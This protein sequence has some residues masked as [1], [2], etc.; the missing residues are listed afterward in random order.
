MLLRSSSTPVLGSLI[1]SVTESPNNNHHHSELHT[2]SS[3]IHQNCSK[4][5]CNNGGSQKFNKSLMNSPSIDR[6]PKTGF[7]RVQSEGNLEELDSDEFKFSNQYSK[8]FARKPNLCSLE[9]IPS[10]THHILGVSLEVDDSD[11]EDDSEEEI[12]ETE[13]EENGGNSFSVD[14]FVSEEVRKSVNGYGDLGFENEGKMYLA[15]GLGISG[16]GF[17]DVCGNGG[18]HGGGGS[19]RPVAFNRDG[20]GDNRGVSMEEHYKS[21]MQGNPGNPLFLRNYAQFLY[22]TKGDLVGAEEY[23]SRAI[24]A[25]P[26]D[27]EILAQYAKLIWELHRD[28][29]RAAN[30]FERAV[31]ASSQDSHIHAAYASFLWDIEDDEDEEEN[32]AEN[33][34]A[35]MPQFYHGIMA[36]ASA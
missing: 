6:I 33:S 2:Q 29:Q 25:D 21:M 28:K 18:G 3:T 8:K 19:Y 20:G 22:Q 15:T 30:Y 4:L 10:F 1:S 5:T 24:L 7:R 35:R 31:R 27:G 11:E 14:N 26:E 34:R 9:S 16:L 32:E 36:S 12:E 13:T 17:V 23:Y